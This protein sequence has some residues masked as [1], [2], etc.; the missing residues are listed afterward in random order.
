VCSALDKGALIVPVVV[1][2]AFRF[3]TS[4]FQQDHL[5]LAMKAL[6][7]TGEAAAP[8]EDSAS[9]AMEKVA[10]IFQ[11]IAVNFSASI[12]SEASLNAA[13]RLLATR[14]EEHKLGKKSR[15]GSSFTARISKFVRSATSKLSTSKASRSST[16]SEGA[17][18]EQGKHAEPDSL[19]LEYCV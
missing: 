7:S 18:Q 12:D 19:D 6:A 14:M 2:D 8:T 11:T 15:S 13:A 5:E 9:V 16:A 3:P 10:N 4:S 17:G 1:N